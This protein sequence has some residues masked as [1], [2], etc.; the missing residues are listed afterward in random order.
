M[1]TEHAVQNIF[2]FIHGE[3]PEGLIR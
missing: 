3:K 2:R 1:G